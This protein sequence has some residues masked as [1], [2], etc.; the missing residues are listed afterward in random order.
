MKSTTT[1]RVPV[2]DAS[3][4]LFAM[5]AAAGI[6]DH[7]NRAILE[8]EVI[9][10]E[11]ESVKGSVGPGCVCK[12]DLEGE[13]APSVTKL[14]CDAKNR[15]QWWWMKNWNVLKESLILARNLMSVDDVVSQV[16]MSML[17]KFQKKLQ[18]KE[19]CIIIRN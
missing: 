3:G 16:P 15:I 17:Y 5:M 7:N 18:G 8:E 9:E 1:T 14:Q 19:D 2:M 12:M 10:V 13:C 6:H 4:G 11:D